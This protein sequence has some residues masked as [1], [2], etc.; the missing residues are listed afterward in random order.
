MAEIGFG[1][2]MR[3]CKYYHPK[4]PHNLNDD[5]GWCEATEWADCSEQ[6]CPYYEALVGTNERKHGKWLHSGYEGV[7]DDE[8]L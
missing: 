1:A 5:S 8:P 6:R 2:M 4:N 7:T 3:I